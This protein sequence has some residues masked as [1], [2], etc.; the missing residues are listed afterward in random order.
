MGAVPPQ[1]AAGPSI[2]QISKFDQDLWD[3]LSNR[4]K[5][6][7]SKRAKPEEIKAALVNT[8]SAR[9]YDRISGKINTLEAQRGREIKTDQEAKLWLRRY[10]LELLVTKCVENPKLRERIINF[11]GM[12]AEEMDK[13]IPIRFWPAKERAMAQKE[14][15]ID[16]QGNLLVADPLQEL[17]NIGKELDKFRAVDD[18]KER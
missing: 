6:M 3:D 16:A 1:V 9:F 18:G 7:V 5:F 13:G 15:L 12:T 2:E 10:L 17:R 4:E 14:G 11:G 8:L